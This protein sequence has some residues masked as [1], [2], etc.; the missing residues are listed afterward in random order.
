[1]RRS[2]EGAV[3]RREAEAARDH[4]GA[5]VKTMMTI[6]AEAAVAYSI[7]KAIAV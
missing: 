1:L 2:V 5:I 6:R 4:R 7:P 3:R